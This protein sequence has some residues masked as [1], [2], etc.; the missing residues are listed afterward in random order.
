MSI[1]NLTLAHFRHFS[2]LFTLSLPST[3]V[4]NPLQI[5]YFYAKQTQ[6]PKKSNERKSI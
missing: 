2:S 4:E 6:S 3:F 5:T 1:E